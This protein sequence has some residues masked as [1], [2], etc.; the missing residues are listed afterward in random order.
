MFDKLFEIP[1]K[2]LELHPMIFEQSLMDDSS[3]KILLGYI[4]VVGS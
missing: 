3:K 4:I 1:L 2:N